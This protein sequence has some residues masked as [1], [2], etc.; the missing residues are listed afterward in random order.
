MNWQ[1]FTALL[2]SAAALTSFPG[3]DPTLLQSHS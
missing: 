2:V 3:A 1:E